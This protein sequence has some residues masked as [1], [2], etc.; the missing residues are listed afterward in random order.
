MTAA[1]LEAV[2]AACAAARKRAHGL[3]EGSPERLAACAELRALEDRAAAMSVVVEL[4]C[5]ACGGSGWI[6]N[7]LSGYERQCLIC[8]GRG[9][10]EGENAK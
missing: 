5:G 4:P 10:I 7:V 6:E 8:H 3:P 9:I 2:R 1:T